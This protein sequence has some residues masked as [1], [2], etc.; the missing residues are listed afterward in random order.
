MRCGGTG[1][2]RFWILS[3]VV[4]EI[5]LVVV[6]AKRGRPSSSSICMAV[7]EGCVGEEAANEVRAAG[8]VDVSMSMSSSS[9]SVV[10]GRGM[11][12]A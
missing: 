2:L 1:T 11:L 12:N 7:S 4:G 6:A 8:A 5:L 3:A 10:G 9:S